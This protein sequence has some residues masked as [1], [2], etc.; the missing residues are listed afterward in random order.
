MQSSGADA[1]RGRGRVSRRQ[2]GLRRKEVVPRT[3]LRG[4]F[5][6][7]QSRVVGGTL[8]CFASLAMTEGW[9]WRFDTQRDFSQGVQRFGRADPPC[10]I[11]PQCVCLSITEV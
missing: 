1:P 4:A 5:A 11:L 10:V 6:P 7:K 9:G 2:R 8:D 3:S